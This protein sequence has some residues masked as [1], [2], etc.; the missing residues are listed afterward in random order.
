MCLALLFHLQIGHFCPI[1]LFVNWTVRIHKKAEKRAKK[2]PA[3]VQV[4]WSALIRD[5]KL[6]GPVQYEWPNY[7]KLPHGRFHCHLNRNYVAVWEMVDNQVRI[8]EVTYVGSREDAP[9]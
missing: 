3:N 4:L 2:L 1:L 5:L 7:S 9:Y 6:V 8:L